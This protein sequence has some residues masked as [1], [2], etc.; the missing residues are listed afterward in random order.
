I[1]RLRTDFSGLNAHRFRCRLSPTAACT[2][3]GAAFETRAHFL[4]HC[5]AWDRFRP[6][7]QHASYTAGILGAV[8][9][10]TLLGHPKLLKAVSQF[11][12]DTGRF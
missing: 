6:A 9:V 3:C 8:D 4:L 5:P 2:S 10:S 7:L 1:S 12:T 11:I